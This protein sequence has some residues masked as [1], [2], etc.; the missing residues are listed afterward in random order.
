MNERTATKNDLEEM[1]KEPVAA[2]LMDYP[3]IY[4]LM[5]KERSEK[6]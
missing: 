5:I 6:S 4:L 3:K 2:F 1:R